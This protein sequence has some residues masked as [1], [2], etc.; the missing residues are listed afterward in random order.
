MLANIDGRISAV[1]IEFLLRA[2]VCDSDFHSSVAPKPRSFIGQM[3]QSKAARLDSKRA[4]E[5]AAAPRSGIVWLASYPKSGNTWTR[6]FLHNLI[7]AMSG[8]NE[9]QDINRMNRYSTGVGGKGLYKEILGFE[10]TNEHRNQIAAARSQ[11]Q[12]R[13]AEEVDGVAFIKT[14]QAL[15]VDRGHPTINFA[16]TAGAIYIVRNPLDV[17]ISYAHYLQQPIDGVIEFMGRN[18]AETGLTEKQVY[19][20]YGS[21]SQH[22]ASWTRKPHQAIYVMRYE[23]MLQDPEKTFGAL[24]AHLLLKPTPDELAK[25]IRRSSFQE[26]KRQ[27]DD[28][29]FRE[30][31]KGAER[32]FRD[33]RA[34]QWKDVLS[35][36]QVKQIV[37]DHREQMARFNYLPA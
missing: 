33:G 32:F 22:V 26:L 21:W 17:A 25:A 37:K 24:A 1:E 35:P 30:R 12:Q 23:D 9:L 8:E 31:P 3:S 14:H 10:P 15:M 27:E 6:A 11:V 36:A 18:D 4:V 5:R 28:K 34:G 13:V 7:N 19:E 16:V 20:V 2:L 29:G